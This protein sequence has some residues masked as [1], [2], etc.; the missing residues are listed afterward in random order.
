VTL[1]RRGLLR[2]LRPLLVRLDT[3]LNSL[4]DR[5]DVADGRLDSHD[6]R[7]DASEG[8]HD[9]H[10]DRLE[11]AFDKIR[12]AETR[13]DQAEARLDALE[14][15]ASIFR[16][17]IDG[18]SVHLNGLTTEHHE[19]RERFETHTLES[20]R[21]DGIEERLLAFEALH[22]DH[23]ALAR[24]LA[25]LEDLLARGDDVADDA[26]TPAERR[27]LP[28]PGLEHGLASRIG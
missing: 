17:Q 1:G 21:I 10:Q 27:S 18:T 23:V 6:S 7:L 26:G 22:W 12:Y 5:L 3:L 8:R 20:R 11:L 28:F 2:A 16:R 25:V 24:R 9:Q 19:L 4:A 15:H 13:F 14:T